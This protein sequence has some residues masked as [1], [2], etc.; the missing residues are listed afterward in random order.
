ML[1]EVSDSPLR[2]TIFTDGS[3]NTDFEEETSPRDESEKT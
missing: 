3:D 1:F 2:E